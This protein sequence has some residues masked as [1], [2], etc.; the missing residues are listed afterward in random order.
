MTGVQTCALPIYPDWIVFFP[1]SVS[2]DF[3]PGTLEGEDYNYGFG[4]N[5]KDA[6]EGF[7]QPWA[8]PQE[9]VT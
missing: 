6:P 1:E 7:F 8:I 9:P 2:V 5:Y 3:P 4:V